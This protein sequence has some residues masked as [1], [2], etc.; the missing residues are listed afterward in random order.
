MQKVIWGSKRRC[1]KVPAGWAFVKN[2]EPVRDTDMFFNLLYHCWQPI[3]DVGG[4]IVAHVQLYAGP[5]EAFDV[6]IRKADDTTL[7][8]LD[9]DPDAVRTVN[10]S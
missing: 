8:A 7:R 6:V 5:E 10:C 1:L 9:T 2:S 4:S 3:R